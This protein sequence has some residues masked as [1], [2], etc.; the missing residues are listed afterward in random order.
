MRSNDRNPLPPEDYMEPRCLLC[1]P[2]YGSVPTVQS[3]PQQRIIQKLDDYMAQKDYSGA[4]R[5]LRYWLEEARLESDQRGELLVLNEMIGFYRKTGR[6]E[7]SLSSADSAL[8]MLPALGFQETI[9]AGTTY[10]NAATAHYTFGDYTT[11]L[12]L[13]EKAKE[14]YESLTGTRPELL[15]GLYNNMGL[16]CVSLGQY[17]RALSFYD[18]AMGCM[19]HVPHGELE[20]AITCLNRANAIEAQFG[21]DQSEDQIFPLLDQAYSL[22]ETS[23]APLNGYYAFVCESCAPTFGYYGYFLA[24]KELREKARR[25]YER[26]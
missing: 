6:K 3:V 26:T 5:H 1:D 16:A 13:F 17:D 14:I 24:E 25:I 9:S 7:E 12:D 4:E 23:K 22:L 11:S 15:G 2:P 19:D 18:R 20:Q 21:L 10:T 8:K